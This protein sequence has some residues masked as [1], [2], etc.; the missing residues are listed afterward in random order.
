MWNRDSRLYDDCCQR[1]GYEAWVAEDWECEVEIDEDE[2]EEWN[3][4]YME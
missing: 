1:K 2:C 4:Y 3:L